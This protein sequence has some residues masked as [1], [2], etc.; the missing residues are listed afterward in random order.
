M[1][2]WPLYRFLQTTSKK[3]KK[4]Y[5]DQIMH[6]HDLSGNLGGP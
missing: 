1:M 3:Q 4:M 6:V 2:G 5:Y